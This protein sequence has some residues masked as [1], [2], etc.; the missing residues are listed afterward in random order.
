[1]EC[2]MNVYIMVFLVAGRCHKNHTWSNLSRVSV[3][4]W[5]DC[6]WGSQETICGF[7]KLLVK[8]HLLLLHVFMRRW[9]E[10]IA[11]KYLSSAKIWWRVLLQFP[12]TFISL[13]SL[14]PCRLRMK[15]YPAVV[16]RNYLYSTGKIN[17]TQDGNFL[18]S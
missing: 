2:S 3:S 11:L 9:K 12:V 1:M 13:M 6:Y 17:Q 8:V 7:K 10:I 16:P 15:M 5:L 14:H 4:V 18:L